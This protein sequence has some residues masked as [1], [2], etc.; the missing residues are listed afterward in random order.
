MGERAKVGFAELPEQYRHVLGL[1]G[2]GDKEWEAVRG[3][4]MTDE[5]GKTFVIPEAARNVPDDV[6][7]GIIAEDLAN[8]RSKLKGDSLARREKQ[9]RDRARQDLETTVN[10]FFA[11]EARFGVLDLDDADRMISNA[12]TKPGTIIGE[13]VRFAMQLKGFPIAFTRKIL[14]RTFRGGAKR[15]DGMF[16]RTD[17]GGVGELVAGMTVAGYIAMTLKDLAKNRTPK[18]LAS[19]ATWTAAALQGGA[20][21]IYGDFFFGHANRFGNGPLETLVGPTGGEIATLVKN[22]QLLRDGES[23]G[24]DWFRQL[25][26]N[27]PYINL[28]YTK[29][30]LDYMVLKHIEEIMSPGIGSR[31]KS[32]MKEQFGQ[33]PILE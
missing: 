18:S 31:R 29:A 8:V 20:M 27:I 10:S 6:I 9:L 13:V 26:G 23:K 25:I 14:G 32:N 17:W 19:P 21:G 15:R 2:I 12:G 4:T 16:A 33:Q 3:M 5:L 11:D 22:A 24:A 7:D 30:A 28:W 1:H